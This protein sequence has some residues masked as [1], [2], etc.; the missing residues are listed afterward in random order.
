[1]NPISDTAYY[2][3][4]VRME[5]AER[6]PSLCNDRFARRFM[7][8]RGMR[9]YEPFRAET[10]PNISNAVRCRII[11]DFVRSELEKDPGTLVV[12]IGAGFDTRPYRLSGGDWIEIDEPQIIQCKNERLPVAECPNP[13]RRISIDFAADP[14]AG[15]LGVVANG[16]PVVVVMEGVFMYLEPAHVDDTL[17]DIKARFPRHVLLC[18]LMDRA[19][20]EKVAQSV[21]SK[22]AAAG[23]VFTE[24]PDD[25]AEIFR[26]NGYM[27]TANVPMFRRAMELGVL[28]D[29]ARIPAV[30]ARLLLGVLRKE[31]NG[32]AVR[33]FIH[34]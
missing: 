17:R 25:P 27:E 8:E 11:D 31:L 18:D 13:L 21:H 30:V 7:D 3:C 23:A 10:L 12:T 22:L 32:F 33:R 1:V 9:L 26:R 2:C 5:D 34:E 19:F 24:R 28:W 16:N 14:L 4:G 20:L 6:K 29:R 15:R